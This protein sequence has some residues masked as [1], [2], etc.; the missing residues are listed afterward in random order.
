LIARKFDHTVDAEILD[1][2]DN[3]LLLRT[4]SG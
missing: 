1:L 3:Q 4:P 2:I